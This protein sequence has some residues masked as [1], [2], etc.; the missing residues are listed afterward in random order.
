MELPA[1]VLSLIAADRVNVRAVLDTFECEKMAGGCFYTY[2]FEHFFIQIGYSIILGT[3]NYC[4]NL[5][6]ES[7]IDFILSILPDWS[8]VISLYDDEFNQLFYRLK[9]FSIYQYSPPH[10]TEYLPSLNSED[11]LRLRI[12]G[13]YNCEIDGETIMSHE[14]E[15]DVK[16]YKCI[17]KWIPEIDISEDSIFT[18]REIEAF[19]LLLLKRA[20]IIPLPAT[21]RK[22][23]Q[24]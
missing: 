2:E 20:G 8:Y 3:N 18:I 9:P 16:I 17:R 23:A 14:G 12:H 4:M 11:F 13:D 21:G 15:C 7:D 10:N 1:E 6:T 22:S 24:S 5:L 19:V